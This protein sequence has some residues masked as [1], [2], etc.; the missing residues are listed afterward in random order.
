MSMTE[1]TSNVSFDMSEDSGSKLK[2]LVN[3]HENLQEQ[4]KTL[5]EQNTKL[6]NDL[7]LLIQ[8]N[9]EKEI[10]SKRLALELKLAEHKI[11]NFQ[12]SALHAIDDADLGLKKLEIL[13]G[14]K[15]NMESYLGQVNKDLTEKTQKIETLEMKIAL[16]ELEK[17]KFAAEN[18]RIKD[19]N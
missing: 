3:A 9:E 13:D 8:D 16:L 19:D 18:A 6:K 7:D 11:A 1:A 15:T 17:N 14:E 4:E 5:Q 2:L 10:D 12:A